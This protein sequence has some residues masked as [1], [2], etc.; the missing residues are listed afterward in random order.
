VAGHVRVVLLGEEVELRVAQ[1][2]VAAVVDLQDPLDRLSRLVPGLL[3]G[4]LLLAVPLVLRAA[5]VLLRLRLGLA[6]EGLGGAL[7]GRLPFRRPRRRRRRRLGAVPLGRPRPP[8]VD[9]VVLHVHDA[10]LRVER[11][12]LALPLAAALAAA[13]AAAP[14]V[15]PEPA[16][17]AAAAAAAGLPLLSLSL[18]ELLAVAVH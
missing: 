12:R 1:P 11:W 15:A 14:A 3:L 17:S 13:P 5:L 18:P 10:A 16:P 8:I 7:G 9:L 6:V 4:A 2:A